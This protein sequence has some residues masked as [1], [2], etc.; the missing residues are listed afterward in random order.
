MIGS[1]YEYLY[2]NYTGACNS[3]MEKYYNSNTSY[4]C[5]YDFLPC[6][7]DILNL[8]MLQ[9]RLYFMNFGLGIKK[10]LCIEIYKVK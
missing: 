3:C 6:M 8:I 10:L 4:I 9:N 2:T 5:S 1:I 7:N